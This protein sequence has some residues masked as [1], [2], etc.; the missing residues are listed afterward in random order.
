MRR[1]R[2][3]MIRRTALAV[4][5]ILPVA[6]LALADGTSYPMVMSLRPVAIQAGTTADMAVHSRYSMEGS[7]RVLIS[8]TGVTGQIQESSPATPASVAQNAPNAKNASGAKLSPSAKAQSKSPAGDK[9]AKKL[10]P[11]QKPS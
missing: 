6:G 3:R 11:S 4:I 5:A 1:E 10:A 2:F 7:Y 8:G 9:L